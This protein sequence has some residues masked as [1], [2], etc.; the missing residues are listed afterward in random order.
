MGSSHSVEKKDNVP[1]SNGTVV[2]KNSDK[3]DSQTRSA[4]EKLT[5]FEGAALDATGAVALLE[6]RVDKGDTEAMWI[7]G[8]CCEYG[9]GM[10][11]NTERAGVLLQ[12]SSDA[13]N[14]AGTFLKSNLKV[15]GDDRSLKA[16]GL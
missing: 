14:P 13:R 8:L 5:G 9:I 11:K 6:A 15:G 16:H 3:M 1:S 7:L 2:A 4:I 12:Q 10:M